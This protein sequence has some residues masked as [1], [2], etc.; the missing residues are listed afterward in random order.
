MVRPEQ[1][2][3]TACAD[4]FR[5]DLPGIFDGAVR[6]ASG[7][8]LLDSALAFSDDGAFLER[9]LHVLAVGKAS[10]HMMSVLAGQRLP[11]VRAGLAI[12]LARS[13][14]MPPLVEWIA[15]SHP[16]PD[17]RSLEAGRRAIDFVRGVPSGHG[18]LVLLSGGASA[19][20]ALPREGITLDDKRTTTRRLLLAGADIHALNAVRKHLSAIKGGQIATAT[21]VPSL[22]LVISDVVGDDPSVIGSGPTV[23]DT[24]TYSDALESLAR[25]GG[26]DA[27][28]APVVALLRS[29]QDGRLP[30]T[31]KPGDVRF[32]RATTRIIGSRSTA[33]AGAASAAASLG[34][35][36]IVLA[37]PI[38]G[39]ARDAGPRLLAEAVR[40]A[41]AGDSPAC[42]IATGETT[43]RVVGRGRGGRNQEFALSVAR[44]LAGAT[45]TLAF[46]SAGTDGID[47]PTDAAGAIADS[48]TLDRARLA[49]VGEPEDYLRENDSYAFFDRLGDLV[50]TGPTDTNVGDVQILLV[51]PP[52]ERQ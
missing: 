17:D 37:D 40:L 15:G 32:A 22:A 52:A 33:A 43:V 11:D 44:V 20:M 38:I 9:P 16:V 10:T 27:Y 46:L 48:T 45:G 5:R 12:G 41:G 2:E 39:E 35:R 23:P 18:L 26:I 3:L 50:K 19:L 13:A 47:G 36:V 25:F 31:P 7:C 8:R 6:A 14:A 30:E 51:A 4:R 24:S 29:G 34:Y 28:P 21:E 42:V 1:G 49:G